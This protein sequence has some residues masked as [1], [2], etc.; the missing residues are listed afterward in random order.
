M[1]REGYKIVDSDTH[2]GPAADILS[3][4]LTTQEQAKLNA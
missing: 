4:Y 3:Q 1:A 2:V